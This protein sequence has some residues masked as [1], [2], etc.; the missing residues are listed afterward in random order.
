MNVCGRK[1][2]K[3]KRKDIKNKQKHCPRAQ[4]QHKAWNTLSR[5]LEFIWERHYSTLN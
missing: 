5:R 2:E 1:G 4:G 3:E